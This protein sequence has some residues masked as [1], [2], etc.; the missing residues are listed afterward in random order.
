MDLDRPCSDIEFD[1]DFDRDKT[2]HSVDRGTYHSPWNCRRVF[3][4]FEKPV[5]FANGEG[6][7]CEV[8][9]WGHDGEFLG[10]LGMAATSGMLQRICVAVSRFVPL[11]RC[12]IRQSSSRETKPLVY[13]D[14]SSALIRDGKKSLSMSME[15]VIRSD[16]LC[17]DHSLACFLR[18]FLVGKNS[19]VGYASVYLS[20]FSTLILSS[21]YLATNYLARQSR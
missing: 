12:L 9:G 14:L 21:G 8:W 4:I 16:E 1:L 19:I 17:C 20:R 5:F 7:S 2:L 3:Q 13:T 10:A 11:W 15:I 6:P 18:A